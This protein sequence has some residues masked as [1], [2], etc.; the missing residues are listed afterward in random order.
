MYC[1]KHSFIFLHESA[2]VVFYML[3]PLVRWREN[4]RICYLQK[5]PPGLT[6]KLEIAEVFLSKIPGS[7]HHPAFFV[8]M[9]CEKMQFAYPMSFPNVH[10]LLA[11]IWRI[12][13]RGDMR[14]AWRS[15]KESI[16]ILVD[17]NWK[18]KVPESLLYEILW[19]KYRSQFD[20]MILSMG[21][22][23]DPETKVKDWT[24]SNWKSLEL[25]KKT[26]L[27]RNF[28]FRKLWPT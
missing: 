15:L 24:Q 18:W 22:W 20:N 7:L 26:P 13:P 6:I 2:N 14:F 17:L 12:G 23:R 9:A 11:E 3:P 16:I 28:L 8:P 21:I 10:K 27:L 4:P 5:L 25:S 1:L 19:G